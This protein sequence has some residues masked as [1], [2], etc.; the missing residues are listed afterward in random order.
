ML[1]RRQTTSIK[2]RTDKS[3][4]SQSD[5]ALLRPLAPFRLMP[6]EFGGIQRT[7]HH[8]PSPAPTA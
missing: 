2:Q 1:Q 3:G 6:I 5:T 8:R 7:C 4:R